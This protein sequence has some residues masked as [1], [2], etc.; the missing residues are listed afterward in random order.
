M[1]L[2]TMNQH[3]TYKNN[4]AAV[5]RYKDVRFDAGACRRGAVTVEMALTAGLAFMFFFASLE[6]CRV[7]MIR[8]TTEHALYEGARRGIVP[9][10]TATEVQSE[11]QSVLRTIGVS[12]ATITV[13]PSTILSDTRD[14]TVRV[15]LPL[16]RGLFAPALFFKGKTLDK[17]LVMQREG[18]R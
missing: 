5:R 1:L 2:E 18:V 10:A 11:V 12:G 8:H 3:C 7:S 13:T 14:V 17:S 15:Q 9:G 6:F 4:R 16:D